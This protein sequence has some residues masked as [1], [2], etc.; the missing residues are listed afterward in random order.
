MDADRKIIVKRAKSLM[1]ICNKTEDNFYSLQINK[2]LVEFQRSAVL[3][4][5][6][7]LPRLQRSVLEIPRIK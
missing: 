5:T 6:T 1:K 2:S 3:S 4:V 7:K